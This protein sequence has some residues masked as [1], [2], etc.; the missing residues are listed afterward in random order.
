MSTSAVIVV[1]RGIV[2]GTEGMS[3]SPKGVE[4]DFPMSA[5]VDGLAVCSGRTGIGC[6]RILESC[7]GVPTSGLRKRANL[8]AKSCG[9]LV[10]FPEG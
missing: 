10:V 8:A 2:L 5:L 7:T 4:M 1:R 3:L 9:E 6:V